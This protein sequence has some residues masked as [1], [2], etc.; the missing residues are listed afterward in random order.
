MTAPPRPPIAR[1]FVLGHESTWFLGELEA[2][3]LCVPLRW[4]ACGVLLDPHRS[5]A[6]LDHQ[7]QVRSG[8]CGWMAH[9]T[10]QASGTLKP[11]PESHRGAA[12]YFSSVLNRSYCFLVNVHK[13]PSKPIRTYLANLTFLSY[14]SYTLQQVRYGGGYVTHTPPPL[15]T[16]LAPAV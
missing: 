8:E 7:W 9:V 5:P 1:K 4:P 13:G 15:V 3:S 11:L 14:F 16:G 12:N 6:R 10:T 2:E